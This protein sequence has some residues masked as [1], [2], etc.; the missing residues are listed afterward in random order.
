MIS[1]PFGRIGRALAVVICFYAGAVSSNAVPAAVATPFP[2]ELAADLTR[3]RQAHNIPVLAVALQHAEGPRVLVMGGDDTTPLRWGSITKTVTALTVLNLW[4]AGK[5]DLEA[6]LSRYVPDHF[7]GNPWRQAH[8]V[9]VID[10]L[11]LRAGFPDLSMAEFNFN[12]PIDLPAALALNPAHRVT[13]WPPGLQHAYTNLA[14][15]LTQLLI[16]QVTGK[17][18]ADAVQALVFDPIG[19]S[20]ASFAPDP[21]LPGGFKADGSTAIPYWHMT[22]PAYGA[23]NASTGDMLKLVSALQNLPAGIA[24]RVFRPSGRRAAPE[25][26][27]DYAAGLYPRVRRGLVWHTHGGDADGYRSRMALMANTPRAYLAN[28]NIDDPAVLRRIERLLESALSKDVEKPS[29]PA[30]AATKLD[31][32]VGT[33][34]PTATRFAIERWQ[35]GAAS[36]AEIRLED[37]QLVFVRGKRRTPLV[38]VSKNQF[39]REDDPVAT[40]VFFQRGGSLYL[41]GELGNFARTDRCPDFMRAIPRCDP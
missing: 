24:E 36:T 25:F 37:Q 8:P 6:P 29:P 17:S 18:Y 19:M 33:Y 3:L 41:Q 27:F 34:Y 30:V 7:W 15:G 21:G 12:D 20:S 39:R 1:P 11:E 16:E 22:F 14:P 35:R 13:R 31:A 10:L 32:F 23:M 4:A 9:R 38:A 40:V 5:V 28:I 26:T 2:A